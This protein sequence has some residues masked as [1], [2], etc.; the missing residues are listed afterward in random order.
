MLWLKLYSVGINVETLG[1]FHVGFLF[2][3]CSDLLVII[4]HLYAVCLLETNNVSGVCIG[5]AIL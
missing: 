5:A 2:S 4:N 3:R 1:I